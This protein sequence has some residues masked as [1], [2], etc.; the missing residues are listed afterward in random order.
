MS[1]IILK[2][3]F[4]KSVFIAGANLA[5]HGVFKAYKVDSVLFVYA[6]LVF[7]FLGCLVEEKN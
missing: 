4:G 2:P 5:V 6:P 1:F 7:K 3:F